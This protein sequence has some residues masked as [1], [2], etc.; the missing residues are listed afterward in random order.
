MKAGAVGSQ[1]TK[2]FK[3]ASSL[4]YCCVTGPV[5]LQRVIA[6]ATGSLLPGGGEGARDCPAAPGYRERSGRGQGQGT[7]WRGW[8]LELLLELDAGRGRG[9]ASQIPHTDPGGVQGQRAAN[10]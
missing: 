1:F 6:P 8:T 2:S 10:R 7:A 4:G 5:L 9:Q 3:Q